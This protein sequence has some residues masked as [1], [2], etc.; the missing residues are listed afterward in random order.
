MS[1]DQAVKEVKDLLKEYYIHWD[2]KKWKNINDIDGV[3]RK[4]KKEHGNYYGPRDTALY[5]KVLKKERRE[6][7]KREY[8]KMHYVRM[9][10]KYTE[11]DGKRILALHIPGM[12]WNDKEAQQRYIKE[13]NDILM[14]QFKDAE[15]IN[16]DL[17]NNFGGKSAVMAAA[18]SP[19]FN[20][21]KRKRLSYVTL[22]SGKVIPDMV[23][24][25]PGCYKEPANLTA[26][27]TK[28]KLYNLKR[29]NIY[30]GETWSAGE[31]IAIMFKSM[32]G[33]PG[34]DIRFHG[35]KTGGATT[36]IMYKKLPH[37]GAMEL[38]IGYMTDAHGVVYKKGVPRN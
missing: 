27:G 13:G 18:L 32:V 21:S 23:R 15:E 14:S 20:L 24:T 30:M 16:I 25:S 33:Q 4:F 2:S 10:G 36:S 31:V 19:I 6:K 28:S 37:G 5:E 22:R 11:R 34:L 1:E 12:V 7:G 26:C 3:L 8:P 35:Y 38:P 9:A 29:I 17:N